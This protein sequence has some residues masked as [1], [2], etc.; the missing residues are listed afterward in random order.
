MST[1]HGYAS[2][3]ERRRT[4]PRSDASGTNGQFTK[5]TPDPSSH[6]E[7]E[8]H[9]A[10]PP[11][12]HIAART[13]AA[14]WRAAGM[15]ALTYLLLGTIWVAATNYVLSTGL[16][17]SPYRL[18][19]QTLKGFVF[20]AASALALFIVLRRTNA[21]LVEAAQRVIDGSVRYED[22]FEHHPTPMWVYDSATQNF[23]AVN[24][25]AMHRYGFSESEFLSMNLRDIRPVED[26]PLLLAKHT[27]TTA[28][29]YGDAGVWRHKTKTGE[30]IHMLIS[31]NRTSYRGRDATL[32][33]AREVTSDVESRQALETLKNSLEACVAKRTAELQATNLEL[34]A[35]ARTAAHDLRTPL[36]GILGFTQ[37]LQ[38][39]VARGRQEGQQD[40]LRSIE[41]SAKAMIALIEGLLAMS[42]ASQKDL[43][44]ED[45]D[46]STLAALSAE[47]LRNA[48]PAQRMDS[49][50]QPG[51]T[52]RGDPALLF[53]LLSNLLSNAWKYSAKGENP[54]I[55]FG[56][57]ALEDGSRVY[58]V[59]D[60][61]VGFP[62]EQVE[63]LFKP[64]QRLHNARDFQ[65]HGVGLVTCQRV[66][67]RHGGRIWPTSEVG[68]GT[69]IWFTLPGAGDPK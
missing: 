29:G 6:P 26:I 9:T 51:L 37:L 20:V 11:T 62:M 43:I 17:D 36:N 18:V 56:A 35:F 65:G 55:E 54:R 69:T 58:F 49:Q 57:Q 59:K 52:A 5:G 8:R 39:D 66:I 24:D 30:V 15:V 21:A 34:D 32:V 68:M 10:L 4:G 1:V 3:D 22:M 13:N 16:A 63:R 41:R 14:A 42:R 38:Q 67:L 40:S 44:A 12:S 47:Q 27:S 60:N 61:G 7:I 45:V 64:F 53:S 31:L 46:L 19:L 25:A 2:P 28:K 23:L 50:I 33:S 48:E